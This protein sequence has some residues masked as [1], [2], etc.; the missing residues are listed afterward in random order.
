LLVSPTAAWALEYRPGALSGDNRGRSGPS[1]SSSEE[2]ER[3]SS[4]AWV[5]PA[6][7]DCRLD[8]RFRSGAEGL[9]DAGGLGGACCGTCSGW[10]D[11]ETVESALKS[12]LSLVGERN[13]IS[14]SLPSN[15]RRR[16]RSS[17]SRA[18]L[19]SNDR[20]VSAIDGQWK[21]VSSPA[22]TVFTWVQQWS[23]RQ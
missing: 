7:S 2:N 20:D 8:L 1:S 17:C 6:R 3:S 11:E 10:M 23:H 15:F 16:C 18:L 22:E 14:G 5:F 4:S 9:E 13:R 21:H 19:R 12:G